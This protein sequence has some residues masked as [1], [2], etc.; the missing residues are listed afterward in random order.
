[1]QL[2]RRL[3]WITDT[4]LVLNVQTVMT[5]GEDGTA[6][7]QVQMKVTQRLRAMRGS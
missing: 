7:V 5:S 6:P 3:G 4:H 2:D 1:M